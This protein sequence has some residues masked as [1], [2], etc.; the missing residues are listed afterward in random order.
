MS[1][2]VKELLYSWFLILGIVAQICLG[3]VFCG[4]TY[5]PDHVQVCQRWRHQVTT[6]CKSWLIMV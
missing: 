6:T 4:G 5:L 1:R 3:L 2:Y